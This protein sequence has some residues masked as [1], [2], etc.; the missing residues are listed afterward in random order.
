[1]ATLLHSLNLVSYVVLVSSK[2]LSLNMQ[3]FLIGSYLIFADYSCLHE[4]MCIKVTESTPVPAP[5]ERL[6]G[7]RGALPVVCRLQT[8][9]PTSAPLCRSYSYRTSSVMSVTFYVFGW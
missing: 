7:I 1:M 9:H 2:R 3:F 5:T 8:Q 4:V 6:C